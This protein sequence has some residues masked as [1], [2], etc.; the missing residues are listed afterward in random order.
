MGFRKTPA[1]CK[2]PGEHLATLHRG[3]KII[4]KSWQI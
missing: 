3:T 2:S 1:R 4:I